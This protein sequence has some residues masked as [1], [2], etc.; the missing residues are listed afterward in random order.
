MLYDLSEN[1]TRDELR[2]IKFL[3]SNELPRRKLEDN[4]VSMSE[5][6]KM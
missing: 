5:Q 1:I 4:L 6:S 2:E 3:L